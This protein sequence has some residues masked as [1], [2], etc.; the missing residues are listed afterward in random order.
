MTLRAINVSADDFIRPDSEARYCWQKREAHRFNVIRRG[1][2]I[3][4]DVS[5]DLCYCD[6]ALLPLDYGV[7]Y[8]ISTDGRIL[9][10][11]FA[12]E[13]EDWSSLSSPDAGELGPEYYVDPSQV[14]ATFGPVDHE[15]LERLE[16]M[17]CRGSSSR[18]DGGSSPP[19]SPDAGTPVTPSQPDGG[20]PL[21]P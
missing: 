19:S 9:R 16:R 20:T 3:F 14:G 1:D 18:S 10:R 8:A 6:T 15:F 2:I 21:T 11:L 5:L 7:S 17:H 12:G 13:P 4:V